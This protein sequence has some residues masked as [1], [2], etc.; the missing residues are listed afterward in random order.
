MKASAL[1]PGLLLCSCAL[2]NQ[3]NLQPVGTVRGD[4]D[5]RVIR[6]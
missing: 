5:G 4:R 3:L 2:T 1:L 6:L